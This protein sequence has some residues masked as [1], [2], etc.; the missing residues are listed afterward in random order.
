MC[1]EGIE[2]QKTEANSSASNS[3]AERAIHTLNDCQH[4]MRADTD[5]PDKYWGYAILHV[6]YLWNITPKRFL[7]RKMLEETFSSKIP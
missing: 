7:N 4:A 3:V 6:V 2:H 1:T 5:L